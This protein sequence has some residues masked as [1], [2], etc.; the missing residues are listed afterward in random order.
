M[1]LQVRVADAGEGPEG[2]S[3]IILRSSPSPPPPHLSKAEGQDPPL[4]YT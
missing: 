4:S 1:H 2:P 3:K